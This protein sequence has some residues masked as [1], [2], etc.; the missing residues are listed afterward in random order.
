MKKTPSRLFPT[1]EVGSLPKLPARTSALEGRE[2]ADDEMQQLKR[3]GL[4]Y[5]VDSA[6]AEEVIARLQKEKRKPASEERKQ[7]LDFNALLNLRIQEKSG[8]DFVYDGE[9]RRSEM[10]RHVV[11]QVEGFEDLPEM[12]R[13]QEEQS[14]RKSVC[15]AEP[16]LKLGALSVLVEEEFAFAENNALHKVKVPLND[17]YMIAVMSDNRHYTRIARKQF[18]EDVWKQEYQAKREFTL[19]LAKDII[20]PQVEAVVALGASWIQLDLPCATVNVEHLPIVVEGVN[21]VVEGIPASFSLH[22]CYPRRN[23]LTKKNGYELLYPHVLH[24]DQRVRH[25]SLELANADDYESDL[26]VFAQ[27]NTERKFDLGIGVIDITLGRHREGLYEK[28]Q[29]VRERILRAAEVLKDPSL[30]YVAPDCGLRQL[31]LDRC[32]RLYEIMVEGAELARRG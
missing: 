19:A 9:A 29:L 21:A 30:V 25:F 31:K 23:S 20:R 26:A 28:P 27:Y 16:K 24:L 17:P 15:V 14:Y 3:L 4:K 13:S 32:I 22:F 18:P 8:I 7:L 11:Q 1:Y 10:Y 6:G 2:V 12:I 5:G